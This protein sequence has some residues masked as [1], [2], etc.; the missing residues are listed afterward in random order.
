[1]P[2][3]KLIFQKAFILIT[4]LTLA[5]CG[6]ETDVSF[7]GKNSGAQNNGENNHNTG[8]DV[9]PVDPVDP[10]PNP[11]PTVPVTP[12][13]PVNPIP[14]NPEPVN[15]TPT[16]TD[17]GPVDPT[18]APTDPVNYVPSAT[19]DMATTEKNTPVN[20]NVL[21]ND[22]GLEDGPIQITIMSPST[23]GTANIESDNTITYT[24]NTDYNGSDNF[25]YKVKDKDND[26]ATA[27][28]TLQITCSTC[29]TPTN[30]S[31]AWNANADQIDGYRIYFGTT[32]ASTNNMVLETNSTSALF[33]VQS[34]LMLNSGDT[35]CFRLK[36]FN[37]IGE[38]GFTDAVCTVI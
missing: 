35:A 29:T 38:S 24:P 21:S 36:A 14:T 15:P 26:M 3:Q 13:D 12:T 4:L 8:D 23:N 32:S 2:L 31:L 22:N 19:N 30:I 10:N 28:V 1:M 37:V 33:D 5:A 18:P 7:P 20:I 6:G 11:A 34:D 16:P 25:S 27:S 17:P 9:G